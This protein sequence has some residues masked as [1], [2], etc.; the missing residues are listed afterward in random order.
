METISRVFESGS[1]GRRLVVFGAIHGN[2]PCGPEA[3]HR[4]MEAIERGDITLRQ[5][6][7][8]FV[9]TCNPLAY[10]RN[11]RCI[12]E[13]LNRVFRKTES[14][15]SYEAR[16]A[17]ELCTLLDTEADM[18]LDIHSTSAP[19]PMSVFVDYPDDTNDAFARALS[20]EYIL[21]DWPAVYARNPHGFKSFCT[22]DYAHAIG[23]PG[24]TV[25]CGQHD[26]PGSIRVA[27]KAIFRALS[28]AGII[29]LSVR[30]ERPPQ[31]IRMTVVEKKASENDFFAK[32]WGHLET[33]KKGETIALRADGST[34]SAPEECMML[35]PKHHA[36][37]GEEW[38]YL[39]VKA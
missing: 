13:N 24:V 5:G 38:Y 8:R 39:G 20:P 21:L 17:N 34:L 35:L 2:E 18:L 29:S 37:A 7:V 22:S 15:S 19:G 27:E 28:F 30:E 3:I 6:S 12:E 33:V 14:P 25:E 4:T 10:K 36:K 1:P 16:L 11:V 9:P 26:D 31:K 23:I 32:Q